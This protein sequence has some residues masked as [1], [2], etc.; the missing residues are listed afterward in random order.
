M[1][2]ERAHDIHFVSFIQLENSILEL[3]VDNLKRL[4][5]EDDGDRQGVFYILGKS[6]ACLDYPCIAHPTCRHI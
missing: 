1:R 5:E 4:N 2:I 3:L 6:R